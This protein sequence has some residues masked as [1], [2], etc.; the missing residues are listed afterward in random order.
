MDYRAEN[1]ALGRVIG[2]STDD[3]HLGLQ[4]DLVEAGLPFGG[5]RAGALGGDDQQEVVM[6]R[7]LVDDLADQVLRRGASWN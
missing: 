3:R 1:P 2:T 5:A 7:N 6:R 4:G